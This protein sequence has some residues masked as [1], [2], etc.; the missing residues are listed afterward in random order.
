MTATEFRE[1]AKQALDL[2]VE[3]Q[4]QYPP[5]ED[6]NEFDDWADVFHKILVNEF[7]EFGKHIKPKKGKKP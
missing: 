1:T 7:D 2:M 4:K 5:K 6:S 3:N